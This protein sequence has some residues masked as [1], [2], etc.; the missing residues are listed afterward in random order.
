MSWESRKGHGIYLDFP[1]HSRRYIFPKYMVDQTREGK[2]ELI[3]RSWVSSSRSLSSRRGAIPLACVKPDLA[4]KENL[5]VFACDSILALYSREHRLTACTI[6]R[7]W[8]II[9]PLNLGRCSKVI[10]VVCKILVSLLRN[11]VRN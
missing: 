8:V 6:R 10:K 11:Q 5:P 9:G 1:C 4:V 2:L 3:S 7:Y